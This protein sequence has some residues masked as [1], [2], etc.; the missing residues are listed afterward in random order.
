ML[1]F[2]DVTTAGSPAGPAQPLRRESATL[3]G[4]G[5]AASPTPLIY[6]RPSRACRAPRH[7]YQR[8]ST[9]LPSKQ[10]SSF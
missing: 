9:L 3:R 4:P 8:H 10:R 7:L 6:A 2:R 5:A 1:T